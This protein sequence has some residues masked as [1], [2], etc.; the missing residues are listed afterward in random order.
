MKTIHSVFVAGIAV[1]ALAGC[2]QSYSQG[3]SFAASQYSGGERQIEGSGNVVQRELAMG[4]FRRLELNGPMNV[5]LRQGATPRLVVIAEDNLIDLIEAETSGGTLSLGTRGSFR[6]NAG[7]RGV[8]TV[9]SLDEATIKGSGDIDVD[10]WNA[11]ALA[12]RVM[13]S[14]DNRLRGAVDTVDA[15]VMGSGDMDLRG[16]SIREATAR[17][18]GSGDIRLGSL[19]RL[20]ARVAGSGDIDAGEVRSVDQS[21]NGSGDIRI[22][23]AR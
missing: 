16:A 6:T 7:L 19:D 1:A 4:D 15:H 11:Q 23:S 13:G 22:V 17:V 5:E 12:L 20:V 2:S 8:L 21:V 18:N 10:G 14:G 9:P 3:D